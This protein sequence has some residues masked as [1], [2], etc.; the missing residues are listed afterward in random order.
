MQLL[1]SSTLRK[2]RYNIA[3]ARIT[4][5]GDWEIGVSYELPSKDGE[6]KQVKFSCDERPRKE[7]IIAFQELLPNLCTI[8]GLD[9][10]A[11]ESGRVSAIAFKEDELGTMVAITLRSVSPDC[12]ITAG[13]TKLYPQGEF[14][15]KIGCAIAEVEDYVDGVREV[16]QLTIDEFLPTEG[17]KPVVVSNENLKEMAGF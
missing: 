16:K 1:Q 15:E 3:I 14:L 2:P 9:R 11:W 10:K 6:H 8:C 13:V 5:K 4:I 7:L 17:F 12:I